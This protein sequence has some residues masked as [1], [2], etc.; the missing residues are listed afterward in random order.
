MK[1]LGSDMC[2]R[3]DACCTDVCE[4]D[5]EGGYVSKLLLGKGCADWRTVSILL[6]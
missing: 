3:L 4:D 6:D 5:D 2:V 1:T